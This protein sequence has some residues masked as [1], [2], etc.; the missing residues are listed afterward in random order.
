MR[1]KQQLAAQKPPQ[2]KTNT[3]QHRRKR[4]SEGFT[5]T[6]K[7]APKATVNEA[8]VVHHR[9]QQS[10]S[11]AGMISI[12]VRMRH[13]RA[14]VR[15][16]LLVVLVRAE[17]PSRL[18]RSPAGKRASRR[19]DGEVNVV[20]AATCAVANNQVHLEQ[21]RVGALCH[22]SEERR[23]KTRQALKPAVLKCRESA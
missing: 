21:R 1:R 17:A 14:L 20:V 6:G 5:A 15:V 23:K 13:H 22:S 11:A 3:T 9:W 8:K 4:D 12:V 16:H 19:E 2:N 10:A 18:T 7:P